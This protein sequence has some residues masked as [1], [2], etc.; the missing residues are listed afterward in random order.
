MSCK[1]IALSNLDFL[2]NIWHRIFYVFIKCLLSSHFIVYCY[3]SQTRYIWQRNSFVEIQKYVKKNNILEVR[4]WTGKF[5]FVMQNDNQ[6]KI[7]ND[8]DTSSLFRKLKSNFYFTHYSWIHVRNFSHFLISCIKTWFKILLNHII[9]HLFIV[10]RVNFLFCQPILC[11]HYDYI[12][13]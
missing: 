4:F 7:K 9:Q 10:M 12:Q 1:L 5:A 3:P 13:S 11:F 8:V 6:N 2:I